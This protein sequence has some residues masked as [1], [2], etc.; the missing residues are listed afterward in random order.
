[1]NRPQRHAR[2]SKPTRASRVAE[3]LRQSILRGDLKPGDKVNLDRLRQI[4]GVSLSPMREAVSRLVSLGLV[5][6]ED[7]RGYR[8]APVSLGN[9]A[10]V[11]RLRADLESL[12]IGYAVERAG[13]DWESEVLGAL[14]RLGRTAH[15]PDDPVS[16]ERWEAAHLAFHMALLR[17]CGMP[18]LVDFCLVLNTLNDRYRRL[19]AHRPA[20]D[21][22]MAVEHAE[23]A[24]AAAVRR[25]RREAETLLR[26]HVERTGRELTERFGEHAQQ[27]GDKR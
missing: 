17:G 21:R 27:A 24:D 22:D 12:A 23:I 3:A 5:E 10:E 9:L 25:D 6:F 20:G 19:F 26:A 4:H 2:I 13:I 16:L 18:M 8:I 1:M 14:H 11:T 15:E 7:Q